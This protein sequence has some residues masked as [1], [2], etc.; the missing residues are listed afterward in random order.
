MARLSKCIICGA[1]CGGSY[2][3]CPCGQ[4]RV[5]SSHYKAKCPSCPSSSRDIEDSD[6]SCGS[7]SEDSIHLEDADVVNAA[8]PAAVDITSN[9]AV[10]VNNESSNDAPFTAPKQADV[11][12]QASAIAKQGVD[13]STAKDVVAAK[14]AVAEKQAKKR[15]RAHKASR[16]AASGEGNPLKK[17]VNVTSVAH[18]SSPDWSPAPNHKGLTSSWLKSKNCDDFWPYF[19]L[20]LIQ[21]PNEFFALCM[22]NTCE[23]H[24]MMGDRVS[25][26][27][28]E[29]HCKSNHRALYDEVH[30]RKA[31]KKF[32][33][34]KGNT[35]LHAFFN[36][37]KVTQQELY[38]QKQ[39]EYIV[40]SYHSFST[41]EE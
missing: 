32:N 9:V 34:L 25:T 15:K 10:I 19:K 24:V 26:S 37:E 21:T 2:Y 35:T 12:K 20:P 1:E 3:Y 22:V 4:Q 13:I 5:C 36:T 17:I 39:L 16:Q 18:T 14:Q 30:K 23:M 41:V 33:S 8:P 31:E 28:L 11:V 27:K 29:Q 38:S 6:S 7:S 40:G